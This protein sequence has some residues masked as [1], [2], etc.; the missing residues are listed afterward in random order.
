MIRNT[1]GTDLAIVADG[2]RPQAGLKSPAR[3][4]SVAAPI[5]SGA[6]ALTRPGLTLIEVRR[7]GVATTQL[8]GAR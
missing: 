4:A 6:A 2:D 5:R 7:F 1:H 8:P 3:R